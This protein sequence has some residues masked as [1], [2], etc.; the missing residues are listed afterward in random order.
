MAGT[1]RNDGAR[2]DM[3]MAGPAT[4]CR[5][6]EGI[7]GGPFGGHVA[8]RPCG[9]YSLRPAWVF[10]CDRPVRRR[11]IV[12]KRRLATDLVADRRTPALSF[13]RLAGSETDLWNL[14]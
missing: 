13:A 10:R 6:P 2:R 7:Y 11:A 1:V 8:G 4:A 5:V 12:R 14:A 3:R 9:N